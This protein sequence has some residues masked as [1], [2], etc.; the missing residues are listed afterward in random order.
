ME[1]GI[2]D[3]NCIRCFFAMGN[4]LGKRSPYYQQEYGKIPAFKA[5]LHF[6]LV[7]TGEIGALKKEIAFT[8]DV[9][10]ATA[11]IQGLC[12]QYGKDLLVS[13]PL[14]ESINLDQSYKIDNLGEVK[15]QGREEVMGLYAVSME[16]L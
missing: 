15:L 3:H 1:K 13:A 11:R 16:P 6:G 12:N 2:K 10:N 14:M 4:D 9:L 8:G 7:T 5:G